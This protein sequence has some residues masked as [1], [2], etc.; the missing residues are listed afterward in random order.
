MKPH[1]FQFCT[2][3]HWAKNTVLTDQLV[4]LKIKILRIDSFHRRVMAEECFFAVRHVFAYPFLYS[5]LHISVYFLI[6][7]LGH[8]I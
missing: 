1:E 7:V 8:V 4:K 3:G 5:V 6:I 2:F